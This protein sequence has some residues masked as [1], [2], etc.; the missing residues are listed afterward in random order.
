MMPIE[1]AKRGDRAA[2]LSDLQAMPGC[3]SSS[4]TLILRRTQ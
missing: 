3:K 4:G 2:I 1:G